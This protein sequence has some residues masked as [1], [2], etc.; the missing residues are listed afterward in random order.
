M[1]LYCLGLA[2]HHKQQPCH[3]MRN[4]LNSQVYFAVIHSLLI[5]GIIQGGDFSALNYHLKNS[6]IGILVCTWGND[7]ITIKLRWLL[8]YTSTCILL[9][10]QYSIICIQK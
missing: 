5:L 6:L 3:M 1:S 10:I 8:N 2:G 7:L 9:I 4:N